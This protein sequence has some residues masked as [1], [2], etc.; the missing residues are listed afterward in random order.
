MPHSG[1]FLVLVF[2]V[3]NMAAL[4]ICYSNFYYF[5]SVPQHFRQLIET[6]G[7][8]LTA[9]KDAF[10]SWVGNWAGASNSFFLRW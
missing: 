10:R 8:N 6:H 7:K 2:V 1:F 3:V 5:S 4:Y 9:L